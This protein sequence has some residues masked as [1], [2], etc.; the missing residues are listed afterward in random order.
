MNGNEAMALKLVRAV[1]DP[2]IV[3]EMFSSASSYDP[4]FWPLHGQLE[5]LMGLKRLN[6]ELGL[7][8]FDET[9]GFK[10]AEKSY[11]NGIC[12]WSKVQSS[13]DL[14]LPTCTL[15]D[16]YVCPGHNADDTVFY[17][18]FLNN[19]ESYTNQEFYDFMHPNNADLPYV[20]D[21]YDFDYCPEMF[22]V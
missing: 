1:E 18:D 3:G 14:T 17:S 20:Y 22:R 6:V 5:R 2:G 11:L 7:V 21:S 19:G 8:D 16:E 15:G 10:T 9:W 12:D 4:L 13:S